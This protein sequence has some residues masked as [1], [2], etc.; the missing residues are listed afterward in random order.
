[1]AATEE[2]TNAV[3]YKDLIFDDS[4][5]LLTEK[6]EAVSLEEHHKATS[7]PN[8]PNPQTRRP[9][10]QPSALAAAAKIQNSVSNEVNPRSVLFVPAAVT[11]KTNA[12][13]VLVLSSSK[14]AAEL[15][16][17]YTSL[18]NPSSLP[19]LCGS[20][21]HESATPVCSNY[22]G[23]QNGTYQIL[24]DGRSVSLGFYKNNMIQIR[25][26]GPN[27]IS[28]KKGGKDGFITLSNAIHEFLLTEALVQL[29]IP[30]T[31]CL[32]VM[33]SAFPCS[34][35]VTP[36]EYATAHLTRFAPTFLRFGHFEYFHL[37]GEQETVRLLAD[38][39]IEQFYPDAISLEN[40]E[41]LYS[42][43]LIA[44]DL[45]AKEDQNIDGGILASGEDVDERVQNIGTAVSVPL[46]R[47]A[48]FFRRVVE[49]TAHMLAHWHANG[50]VHGLMNTENMSILGL[51]MNVARSGI[52]DIYDPQWTSNPAD[53]EGR[54]AF[55]SQPAMAA[56]ALSRLSLSL[57]SL[58]G[59]SFAS[60]TYKPSLKSQ[61]EE[62]ALLKQPSSMPANRTIPLGFMYN[63][64]KA[65]NVLREITCEFDTTFS[66]KLGELFFTVCSFILACLL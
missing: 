33:A 48:I 35:G 20:S 4:L 62:E 1:M 65:E 58:V 19:L 7:L 17:E 46:N 55:D 3:E 59:E 53:K 21:F 13:P 38:S 54:Y 27:A 61:L 23:Y 16:I 63:S 60:P 12:K 6:S 30:T 57:V 26:I 52:M 39:V 25:G 29:K 11:W 36:T 18:S 22:G 2:K 45:F 28:K 37:R 34:R 10:L 32:S 50:F 49:R 56:W 9:S 64:S 31:R 43:N 40:K 24:G 8:P 5:K 14:R 44:G 41:I 47:Y 15:G 51:T 66:K 42:T